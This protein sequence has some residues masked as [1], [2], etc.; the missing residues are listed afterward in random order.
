MFYI[1]YLFVLPIYFPSYP[2]IFFRYVLSSHRIFPILASL[3]CHETFGA[4]RSDG[5]ANRRGVRAIASAL[6][7]DLI[8]L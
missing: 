1:Q 2:S 8:T 6:A 4:V 3:L 5:M 7:C